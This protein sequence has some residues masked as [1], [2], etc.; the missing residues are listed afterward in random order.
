MYIKTELIRPDEANRENGKTCESEP[1]FRSYLLL[2][3]QDQTE[4]VNALCALPES[5]RNSPRIRLALQVMPKTKPISTLRLVLLMQT[6]IIADI[7]N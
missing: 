1:E 6:A 2:L 5:I 4:F 7:S 3:L